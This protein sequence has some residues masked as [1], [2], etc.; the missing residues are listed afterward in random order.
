MDAAC[1][2]DET[3]L[4][5]DEAKEVPIRKESSPLQSEETC[6]SWGLSEDSS[7]DSEEESDE[8]ED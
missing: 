6:D 3:A 2:D 8:E 5:D 7:K 1:R 4:I